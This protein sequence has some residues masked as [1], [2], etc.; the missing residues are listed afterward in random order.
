MKLILASASARRKELLKVITDDFSVIVS[1]F[2][3]S[4]INF[5]GDCKEY[6]IELSKGKALNVA[7]RI[8]EDA[9]IIASDTIVYKDGQVLLKP[10]DSKDAFRMLKELSG[11]VHEVYS[12]I[13]VFNTKTKEMKCDAVCT[14]VKFSSITDKQIEKYINTGEPLDKAGAYGIQG[15]AA[16]FVESINGCYYNVV[17]LPINRLNFLLRDMGVD[18]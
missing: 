18:L 5:N 15:K 8:K 9:F 7:D 17:G 11:D 2:N 14:E 12:G 3:E 6:V 13:V 1:D 10:K 16:V 4:K